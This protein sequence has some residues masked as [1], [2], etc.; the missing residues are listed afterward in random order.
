MDLPPGWESG[1][2]GRNYTEYRFRDPYR[3]AEVHASERE[4]NVAVSDHNGRGSG[5]AIPFRLVIELMN[6]EGWQCMPPPGWE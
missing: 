1:M 2:Y 5:I 4:L 6:G 3:R